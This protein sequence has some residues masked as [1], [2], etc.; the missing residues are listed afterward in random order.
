MYRGAL[1]LDTSPLGF[2]VSCGTHGNSHLRFGPAFPA[3]H[4]HLRAWRVMGC[5]GSPPSHF[6]GLGLG[7]TE[8]GPSELKFLC[9]FLADTCFNPLRRLEVGS[10][11]NNYKQ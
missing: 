11:T 5:G 1:S 2:N 7:V 4:R 3:H 9:L 10:S 8:S 6:G